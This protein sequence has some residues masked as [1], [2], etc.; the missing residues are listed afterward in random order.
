MSSPEPIVVE[1]VPA[2][3]AHT[4]GSG[5][6]PDYNGAAAAYWGL[7]AVA[8]A[9]SLSLS[10]VAL[11]ALPAQDIWQIM[12][13]SMI[14]AVVGMFPLRIPKTKTSI[15]AGD[16]FIFLLL[17]LHGPYAAVIAALG[18]ATNAVHAV[19]APDVRLLADRLGESA[20]RPRFQMQLLSLFG[21][22]ALILAAGGIYGLLAYAVT[23]RQREIGIRMALGAGRR[24]VLGLVISQGMRLV[25]TGIVLGIV[26]AL[27][28]A[29]LLRGLLFEVKPTDPL[30]LLTVILVL[31]VVA[32]LA[33]WLPARRASRVDPIIAL[34]TE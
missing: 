3:P 12:V 14:A 6:L 25:G 32:L 13:A 21:L 19:P 1:A 15:A 10:I 23:R 28:L 11:L 17:L 34:R 16:I 18:V 9:L 24:N 20:A 27:A 22:L 29:R 8:G 26:A 31:A 5:L 7:L 33:C 30:T 2:V 4:G